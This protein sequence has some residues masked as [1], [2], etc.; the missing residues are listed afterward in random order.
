MDNEQ[1]KTEYV[2]ARRAWLEH[3]FSGLNPMQRQAVLA[4]EGPVLILAGAGSGKTTVLIQRIANLLRFGAASDSEQLPPDADEKGLEALRSL[5]PEAEPYAVLDPVRPWRILAITFT[6]K[7][8][9]E[10]KLRLEKLLNEGADDIWACTFHSACLRILRK[11][12]ELLGYESGF[13][14]YDTADSQSLMKQILKDRNLDEKVYQPRSVLSEISRAKDARVLP[15]EYEK[16]ARA[17]GNLRSMRV[18]ELYGEYTRRLF[19]ANA[20]DFDDL[21][22]NTVLLLERYE[23]RRLYWQQRFS[24]IMV[25]EY[26]DTNHLQYLLISLLAGGHGNLC[27]V[28]DDDQSIYRFRGATIENILSFEQQFPG[29]RSIRLEQNYRSTEQILDAANKVIRHNTGRKGKELWTSLGSGE[30]VRVCRLYD[31]NEEAS[32]VASDIL[33]DYSRGMQWQDHAI[34]YRMNAQS[35]QFEFAFKRNGIPYRVIGGARFFDRAEIKDMLSYLSIIQDPKDELRLMRILNVPPRGIGAKSVEAARSLALQEGK[36]LFEILEKAENYPELSRPALRMREFAGMIRDLR[37]TKLGCAELYDLVLEKSGYLRMLE[38]SKDPKDQSRIENVR[39][40]KTSMLG[41]ENETG[42]SSLQAYL[43]NIALYTD[44]DDMDRSEDSVVL[45]TIHSAK[46]LE[47]PVVYVVGMEEGIFPGIRAIGEADEMEE[48]RRLCYV[49]FTRAKKKLVLTHARQRMLFGRTTANRVSRF[50]E[51]SE[52]VS[53]REESERRS[54]VRSGDWE[55]FQGETR[56]DPWRKA[57][58]QPASGRK[59]EGRSSF[60]L[61]RKPETSSGDAS[62][63]IL[64]LR[65][66]QAVTHKAFGKGTVTKMT[67]MGGDHLIEI[68]FESVG[69]KKLMLK[70]ASRFLQPAE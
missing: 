45:M 34:L 1:F 24:Y 4:T 13:S 47:F 10:L 66:G 46:G 15:E 51:E 12:A 28:G 7:A 11:E 26:Q 8:A 39:E 38:E 17:G 29:C 61:R 36:P 50:L 49:A 60:P 35:S 63:P 21:I 58:V 16:N 52:L 65:V 57:S 48:E 41:F 55:D 31:E 70:T 40:L 20:M 67:P 64:Q 42:D 30:D 14:I 5:S 23:D 44:L 33:A 37:E 9:Q 27:V 59:P 32:A 56:G 19:A 54:A 18:A 69:S 6:N 22:L 62:A 43:E 3:R 2:S 25:D 53:G 68:Q